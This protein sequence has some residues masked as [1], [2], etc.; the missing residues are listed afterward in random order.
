MKAFGS[1]FIL[2][3][4]TSPIWADEAKRADGPTFAVPY[5]LTDTKHILVRAWINKLGLPGVESH[6]VLGYNLLPR[7]RIELDFTQAKM[8]WTRLA[9]D[10]P[11]PEGL[12]KSAGMDPLGGF[13]KLVTTLLG[14]KGQREVRMRG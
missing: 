5:R 12:N 10:P 8:K 6:G 11:L 7:Y 3:C 4:L 13:T 1:A 2:V 9:F 14:R